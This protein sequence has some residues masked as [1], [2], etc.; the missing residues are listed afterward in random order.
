MK[1]DMWCEDVEVAGEEEEEGE[2][3]SL[4][5]LAFVM[6]W[7]E[8]SQP[9]HRSAVSAETEINSVF[10]HSAVYRKERDGVQSNNRENFVEEKCFSVCGSSLSVATTSRRKSSQP[11][12]FE[13]AAALADLAAEDHKHELINPFGS[14][15]LD[16][17]NHSFSDK[18]NC[19]ASCF[20]V[21]G[22]EASNGL[23]SDADCLLRA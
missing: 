20:A 4:S 19:V 15:S 7:N 18:K 1:T 6:E 22:T 8:H 23:F 9:Q 16:W 5:E 3:W 17:K 11:T 21:G 10:P 13:F 12:L 2:E 14:D